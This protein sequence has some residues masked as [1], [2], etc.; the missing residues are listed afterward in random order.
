MAR[1]RSLDEN[2]NQAE[3]LWIRGDARGCCP[4]FTR[5]TRSRILYQ[6]VL[7]AGLTCGNDSVFGRLEDAACRFFSLGLPNVDD[8]HSRDYL[9]SDH[10]SIAIN[11]IPPR[12]FVA[13]VSP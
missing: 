6:Q 5:L 8:S 2:G 11:C 9:Q 10:I 12:Y 4:S 3:Q 1:A 7:S 13:R